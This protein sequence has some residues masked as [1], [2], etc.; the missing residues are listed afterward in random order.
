[1]FAR[2]CALLGARHRAVVD[3]VVRLPGRADPAAVAP[4]TRSL[5]VAVSA[6]SVATAVLGAFSLAPF[7][8]MNPVTG[9][10]NLLVAVSFMATATVLAENAP[11]RRT[12]MTLAATA[13]FWLIS[14][15]WAWPPEWQVGP[16]ALL[17]NVTGYLWFV[18]G[19]VGLLR[20][21]DAHLTRLERWY[22]SVMAGWICGC[23]ILIATVSEPGWDGYSSWS[24]WPTLAPDPALH[25]VLVTV[26][27]A[28][29]VTL[30]VTMLLLLIAKLRRSQGMDRLDS[31]PVTVAA[32]TVTVSGGIYLS[33]RLFAF[34]EQ[35][36]EALQ[37]AMGASALVTPLAFLMVVLRRRL[38]RSAVA[39]LVV[40]VAGAPTVLSVQAELRRALQDPGLVIWVRDRDGTFLDQSGARSPRPERDGGWSVQ[41]CSGDGAVLAVLVVDDRLRRHQPLVE[42]SAVAAGLALEV[43][44]Q[45]SE[46]R[47]SRERIASAAVA[48]RRRLERDLHD[49]AQQSLLAVAAR[50]STARVRSSHGRDASEQI[51]EAR[52]AL[53]DALQELRQLARGIHPAVLSQSGLLPAIES[54]AEGLPVTVALDIPDRRWPDPVEST[55]YFLACEAL[56]NVVRHAGADRAV[57][58]V[59]QHGDELTVDIADDG[60]GGADLS[61][62]TGLAGMQD[63]VRAIGGE[64]DVEPA[65]GG[66]TRI[67]AVLP[68]G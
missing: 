66:G 32:S 27:Y 62:G 55:V 39:D 51:D 10:I 9:A 20:Y 30:A 6:A 68:C 59:R 19:G 41:A 25:D 38:S 43:Q 49:G 24:W 31:I 35:V 7:W 22:F 54:V 46:L 13:P 44:A 48:E 58:R 17:S 60:R 57:V 45:M 8:V 2:W 26:F 53:Q 15:W 64:L 47:R 3:L 29:I 16:L 37:T 42:A 67:R 5:V 28:G 12:A 36:I 4:S 56:T 65:D 11:Q 18:F 1:V 50:L 40:A 21:P 63:R 52:T 14:W 33:A 34:P 61:R 23:K